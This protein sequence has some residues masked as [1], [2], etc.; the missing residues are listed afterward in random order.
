MKMTNALAAAA[1]NALRT[2][3]NGGRLYYF[4]GSVPA[5]AGDALDM[6]S[7]HTQL[8]EFTIDGAGTTGLTF[9]TSD[10]TV[11]SKN[12]AETWSGLVAFSGT[13]AG[14]ATLTPTFFRFCP[15]GDNGRGASTGA[16]IQGTIGGPASTAELKLTDGTTVTDNGSNTRSL[17]VFNVE[18]LLLS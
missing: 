11:L 17:P 2:A 6:A 7:D 12:G 16:R 18:L 1:N 10:G 15:S 5:E 4:S 9:A 3:L 8:V 14:S 13:G